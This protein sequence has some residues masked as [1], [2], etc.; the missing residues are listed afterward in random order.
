MCEYA[1]KGNFS[2]IEKI[3]LKGHASIE[4]RNDQGNSLLAIACKY[5]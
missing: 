3:I 2:D 4:T 1:Q 5:N